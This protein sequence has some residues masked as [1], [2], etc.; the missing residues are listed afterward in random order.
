MCMGLSFTADVDTYLRIQYLQ[1]E[2]CTH[3]AC[4]CKLAHI[5]TYILAHHKAGCNLALSCCIF[6]PIY[7]AVLV[8]TLLLAGHLLHACVYHSCDD[9]AYACHLLMPLLVSNAAMTLLHH[10][11]GES[12]SC[13]ARHSPASCE[14]QG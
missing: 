9:I 2:I 13:S 7:H 12:S 1:R 4:T 11:A 8:A 6:A 5:H 10:F 3:K 14:Q